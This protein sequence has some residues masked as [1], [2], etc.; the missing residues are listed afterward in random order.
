MIEHMPFRILAAT[1]I[2]ETLASADAAELDR[3]LASCVA[4]RRELAAMRHDDRTLADLSPVPT[5]SWVRKSLLEE[6]R[7][8]RG[9]ARWLVLAAA[10]MLLAAAIGVGLV[11]GA[12]L[13][14]DRWLNLSWTSVEVA[15]P[16]EGSRI[17]SIVASGDGFVAAGAS[18]TGAVVWTSTDGRRGVIR[19]LSPTVRVRRS[20]RSLPRTTP[21]SPE[22]G[23]RT[24]P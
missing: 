16:E 15:V 11:V 4:C 10:V 14:D 17:R 23:I 7:G 19:P 22:A 18:A 1:S 13:N 12:L 9:P 3:H 8:R 24:A 20:R 6:A 5:A 21:Y 2:D